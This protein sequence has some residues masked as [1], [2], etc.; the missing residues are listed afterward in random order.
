MGVKRAGFSGGA[1]RVERMCAMLC[2]TGR[3]A[4]PH[5]GNSVRQDLFPAWGRAPRAW[6]TGVV[7]GGIATQG[8]QG[9]CGASAEAAPPSRRCGVAAKCGTATPR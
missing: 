5:A 3:N 1:V 2:V 7:S 8:A 9:E 6:R 4:S